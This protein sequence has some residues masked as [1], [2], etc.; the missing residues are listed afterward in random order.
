MFANDPAREAACLRALAHTGLAPRLH[1]TGRAGGHDWAVHGFVRGRLW[2]NDPAIVARV[3][4]RLHRGP[5]PPGLPV[6]NGGSTALARQ[7]LRILDLCTGPM[8]QHLAAL[9]P[10]GTVPPIQHPTPVHGDPVPGNILID[11]DRAVL[12]DWQCPVLGDPAEDLGLFASPAMQM[13]YRGAPL[14]DAETAAFLAACPDTRAV[15]RYHALKP[16][17]H[18]RMAAYCLWQ[19]QRGVGEYRAGIDLETAAYSVA[20]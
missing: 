18:W 11:R 5:P 6:S 14:T 1:A 13:L 8:R 12:I 4:G 9:A 10:S 2:S 20:A 3:L 17:L 7:T 15:A 19:S 16:W